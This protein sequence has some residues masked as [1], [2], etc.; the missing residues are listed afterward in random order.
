MAAINTIAKEWADEFVNLCQVLDLTL[1]DFMA[2][3]QMAE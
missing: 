1:E 2:P 3:A